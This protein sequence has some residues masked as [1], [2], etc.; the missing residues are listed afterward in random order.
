M[1]N[2]YSYGMIAYYLMTG[3]KPF[4]S[5]RS[6]FALFMQVSK[7]KR[8]EFPQNIE[9]QFVDLISKCWKEI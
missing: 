2:M 8:S 9:K 7:G 1:S 4:Y 6:Q 5:T 3:V